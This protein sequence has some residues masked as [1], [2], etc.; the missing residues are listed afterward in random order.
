MVEKK[1]GDR[2]DRKKFKGPQPDGSEKPED[3]E[4]MGQEGKYSVFV[5]IISPDNPTGIVI[6]PVIIPN[7]KEFRRVKRQMW[8]VRRKLRKTVWF[9]NNYGFWQSIEVKSPMVVSA[10]PHAVEG[11]VIKTPEGKKKIIIA[12]ADAPHFN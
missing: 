5:L 1:K 7:K 2:L 10:V 8:L 11:K 9:K 12:G 3:L 4:R 6:A